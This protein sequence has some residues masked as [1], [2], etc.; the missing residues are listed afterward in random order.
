MTTVVIVTS[1]MGAQSPAIVVSV[2]V[3]NPAPSATP[4]S[5]CEASSTHAGAVSGRR[6]ARVSA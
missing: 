6:A 1:A 4:I 5:A 3:S 2:E